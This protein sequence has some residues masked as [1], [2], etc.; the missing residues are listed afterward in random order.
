MHKGDQW[1]L[2][3]DGMRLLA[4]F[5]QKPVHIFPHHTGHGHSR[6]KNINLGN[7]RKSPQQHWKIAQQ[8]RKSI[9]G[10]PIV[11]YYVGQKNLVLLFLLCQEYSLILTLTAYW[12]AFSWH[13]RCVV[14]EVHKLLI[15]AVFFKSMKLIA[16]TLWLANDPPILLT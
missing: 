14:L 2:I 16:S 12:I 7:C 9:V 10:N 4:Q 13:I 11:G 3:L 15:D 8:K 5:S 1:N 6:R